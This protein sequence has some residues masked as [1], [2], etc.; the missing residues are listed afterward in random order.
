[1]DDKPPTGPG[2]K[3]SGLA[4]IPLGLKAKTR[5]N[6]TAQPT[7]VMPQGIASRPVPKAPEAPKPTEPAVAPRRSLFG[8]IQIPKAPKPTEAVP[9][10]ATQIAQVPVQPVQVPAPKKTAPPPPPP[11]PNSDSESESN[12]N[13]NSNSDSNSD[14]DSNTS[15]NDY[16]ETPDSEAEEKPVPKKV[17]ASA[18]APPPPKPSAAPVPT[19]PRKKSDCLGPDGKPKPIEPEYK[20][21]SVA[22]QKSTGKDTFEKYKI[23]EPV[24][25]FKVSNRFSFS[26]FIPTKFTDF[27]ITSVPPA[28]PEACKKMTFQENKY[29][30]FIRE[31]FRL[32]SPTRGALVYHGLGSG[33]TCSAIAAAESLFSESGRK[34]IIMTPVSLRANFIREIKFCGFKIYRTENHWQSLDLLDEDGKI[35]WSVYCF[36]KSVLRV[37]HAYIQKVIE[38]EKMNKLIWVPDM[39]TGKASNYASLKDAAKRQ[40]A[41]QI[42]DMIQNSITFLGYNGLSEKKLKQIAINEP[43]FFDNAIIII[44]EVHNLTSLMRN[45]LS[46]Y[47]D[48]AKPK[49]G[50]TTAIQSVLYDPISVEPWRL[51]EGKERKYDRAYLI[52]RLLSEA[53]NSKIIALSGTPVVN[54]P[55]ELGILG[56]ILHGNFHTASFTIPLMNEKK[57]KGVL[58]KHP[59]IDFYSITKGVKMD[60]F[61]T[62]LER[63]FRKI[64]DP[65]GNGTSVEYEG[66]DT[67]PITDVAESVI[68]ELGQKPDKVGLTY[69]ALPLYPVNS[70]TFQDYFVDK[71]T[72]RMKNS[73]IFMKR[74]SGL[75]SF[76]K[77]GRKDYM[78]TVNKDIIVK[79]PMSDHMLGAYL[80]ARSKERDVEDKMKG[81][82]V[83]AAAQTTG[84]TIA[85]ESVNWGA[86]TGMPSD[87]Q[88][89]DSAASSYR[90][91][92]RALCNFAFPRGIARPFPRDSVEA[93]AAASLDV[94]TYGM[95]DHDRII[96]IEQAPVEEQEDIQEAQNEDVQV[97]QEI[98]AEEV[99]EDPTVRSVR[100][101]TEAIIKAQAAEDAGVMGEGLTAEAIEELRGLPY[102]LRVLKT[103]EKL[104]KRKAEFFSMDPAAPPHK[105]L[106]YYSPKYA[107]MY[108]NIEEAPGSSLVYSQ[109]KTLEGLGIFAI[110]LEANGYARVR[111]ARDG[112]KV[113]FSPE[114][115]AG[116]R[117]NP[118]QRRYMIFS[119][120][121]EDAEFRKELVDIF[122]MNIEEPI[123]SGVKALLTEVGVYNAER[124]VGNQAGEFCRIFMITG[125]GSEGISLKNVRGVHLMEPH[126][127]KVRMDQ[128]KGRAVRI[129][130]HKD[131]A[132]TERN[133]DIYTYLSVLTPKQLRDNQEIVIQDKSMT[134]DEYIYSVAERKNNLNQDFLEAIQMGAVDCELNKLENGMYRC[135]TRDASEDNFLYEPRLELDTAYTQ[136][137]FKKE[138]EITRRQIIHF[139]DEEMASLQRS[140]P[141]Q[142]QR[143]N[144][145]M[146]GELGVDYKL[147]RTEMID[148]SD[149]THYYGLFSDQELTHPI[150]FDSSREFAKIFFEL[151]AEGKPTNTIKDIKFTKYE[152]EPTTIPQRTGVPLASRLVARPAGT[153]ADTGATTGQEP[154]ALVERPIEPEDNPTGPDPTVQG[155]D[156]IDA[157]A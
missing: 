32:D 26:H 7:T 116:I 74:M 104:R 3:P 101:D 21:Y 110:A 124:K 60:I 35:D 9:G 90:F 139:K 6:A 93:D 102:E 151:D 59:Y 118:T 55:E 57:V 34:I 138:T 44:D 25:P 108:K 111:L 15:S 113:I 18:K 95:E 141:R 121:P 10:Q 46:R 20:P 147:I 65:A 140:F 77:G 85:S 94:A 41:Q 153:T 42:D 156:A 119:G 22:L 132:F 38:S 83:E 8:A 62:L 79:V 109:F 5:Q 135:F 63:G 128:V 145:I 106:A 28:D 64:P 123:Y 4:K 19:G 16:S 75:I 47:L 13:S 87:S 50:Q 152:D 149:G 130:S 37:S 91:R 98:E 80:E 105:Q 51:R 54:Y 76:Y 137:Y 11:A 52:Y 53:R 69:K 81:K 126:W 112:A 14:S 1:M 24:G 71:N 120:D 127:N 97:L 2:P 12:S 88:A 72:V 150:P 29:Q 30:Q 157:E 92:S 43:T 36:A 49:K 67:P 100:A 82:P 148:T 45:R 39:R 99:A 31:Y 89:K 129:C 142:V 143:I 146:R 56:N 122:N 58:E 84:T 134:S 125:A 66:P 131:L 117:A 70:A 133:V 17:A 73:L 136:M 33:K 86:I 155:A 144:R 68:R 154:V 115:A 107:T 78:P 23:K 61:I 96:P 48:P 40:I 27:K 103:V 114:T